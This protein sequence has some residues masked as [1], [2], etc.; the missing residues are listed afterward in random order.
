MCVLDRIEDKVSLKKQQQKNCIIRF[1]NSARA[2]TWNLQT[3][4][5]FKAEIIAFLNK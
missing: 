3:E 2:R 1:T 4:F 5:F